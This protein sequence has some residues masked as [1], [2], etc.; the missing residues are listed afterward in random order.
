[1]ENRMLTYDPVSYTG[2]GA[3]G[4]T[5]PA[6]SGT[7]LLRFRQDKLR[8]TADVSGGEVLAGAGIAYTSATNFYKPTTIYLSGR[9]AVQYDALKAYV[10]YGKD[11]WGPVD[12]QTQLGWTYHHIYQAGLSVDFLKSFQAGFRY[13]GTRMTNDFIGS[14]TGAF[15]EYTFYLTYHFT[16][17]KNF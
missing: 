14:D 16:L 3:R 6:S 17:E 9:V 8:I 11:V 7:A 15:N 10:R 2:S 13:V 4:T 12:Y 5:Y 1:D